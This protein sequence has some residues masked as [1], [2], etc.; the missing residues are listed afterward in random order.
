V[1]VTQFWLSQH[2]PSSKG[3]TLHEFDVATKETAW[4]TS[5][6]G[7]DLSLSARGNYSGLLSPQSTTSENTARNVGNS[8]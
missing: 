3:A 5:V 6:H 1:N 8:T 7:T 2:A 4:C